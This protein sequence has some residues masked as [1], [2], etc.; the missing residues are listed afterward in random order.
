MPDRVIQVQQ[1]SIQLAHKNVKYDKYV[2]LHL[3][4]IL[5]CCLRFVMYISVIYKCLSWDFDIQQ[6][7]GKPSGGQPSQV[8]GMGSS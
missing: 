3:V 6:D 2:S 7:L 5:P 1:A 8:I 4:A